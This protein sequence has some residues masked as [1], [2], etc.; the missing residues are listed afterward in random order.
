MKSIISATTELTI[1]FYDLDP[2]GICWHG[3]YVKYFEEARCVLFRKIDYDYTQ[4]LESGYYW[5]VID[6]NIR[7]VNALRYNQK[8][9]IEAG[10][11]EYENYMKIQYQIN[12]K[13]S[14]SKITKGTTTQVAVDK[15]TNEMLIVSPEILAR[16]IS[17][18]L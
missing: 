14:G 17:K 16:K 8:V 6:L 10:L 15:K 9:I 3:N 5:P 4:M 12:D 18:Y 7:Y 13:E 11:V 2:L 1:P